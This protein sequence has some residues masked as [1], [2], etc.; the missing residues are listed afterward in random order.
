M[1]TETPA[2]DAPALDLDRVR[3]EIEDEVRAR[4]ASGDFPP[5]LERDLDLVFARFAPATTSGDDLDGVLEAADRTSFVDVD[6]PTASDLPGVS[7]VK[8]LLRKLM[9]WYLRY[10]AQQVSVFAT[11]AVAALKLLGRRVEALEAASPGANPRILAEARH[12]GPTADPA[13]FATRV[14]T[15]MRRAS[16][17]VLVAEVGS[18]SLLRD[19]VDAGV[20]AY[21]L[22]PG[23]HADRITTTD[24]EIRD[25]ET[26]AHLTKVGEEALGGLVL[27][28][29]ADRLPLGGQLALVE[30]AAATLADGA[31]L[32]VLST[33]PAAWAQAVDPVDADLA[34]GRPLHPAT[35]RHLLEHRGFTDVE[36]HDG[37]VI[38][39]L[40]RV[41]GPGAEVLN[42]NLARIE[43]A[44]FGPASVAVTARRAR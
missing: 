14:I 7:F 10:L 29:G 6:V 32:V 33:T 41:D 26:V 20:D 31:P 37:P 16:G 21:G 11:S 30:R 17:R 28:G 1:S 24:L 13:P 2:G 38:A 35:W 8:R 12:V 44:L 19:L 9:A 40:D 22:D 43:A 3:R 36:V 39:T 25:E 15:E 42:T 4:R 5:G 34:P 23:N 27:A 18:G